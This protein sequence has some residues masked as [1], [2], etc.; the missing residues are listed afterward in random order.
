MR[1][2]CLTL[3][4]SPLVPGVD[5]TFIWTPSH[6]Q[7]PCSFST[8]LDQGCGPCRP[9]PRSIAGARLELLET[10]TMVTECD[11]MRS[12]GRA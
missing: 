1:S 8:A 4:R 12:Y 3:I 2:A 6:D 10:A 5:G 7:R 9:E 11:W